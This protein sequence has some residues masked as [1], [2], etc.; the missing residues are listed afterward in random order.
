[1]LRDDVALAAMLMP[2]VGVVVHVNVF[3]SVLAD[4]TLMAQDLR[5]ARAAA[6]AILADPPVVEPA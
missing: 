2:F 1:M 5:T 4:I 6:A 3:V